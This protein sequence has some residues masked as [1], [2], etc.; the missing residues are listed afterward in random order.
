MNQINTLI[1]PTHACN[2]RC[3]YCFHEKYGY[4][5]EILEMDNLKNYIL[6]QDNN[7]YESNERYNNILVKTK[8]K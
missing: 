1:K 2:M 3:K 5:H 7:Y 6:N 8:R 4:C